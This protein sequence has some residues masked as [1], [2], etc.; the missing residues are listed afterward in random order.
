MENK[1]RAVLEVLGYNICK[2][3]AH[4]FFF[5]VYEYL[6]YNDTQSFLK[7]LDFRKSMK[8]P[9]DKS[10]EDYHIFKYMMQLLLS[11]N[12]GKLTALFPIKPEPSLRSALAPAQLLF[13][14]P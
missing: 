7:M 12:P 14:Q 13:R 11:Q 8:G 6:L 2:K 4:K 5:N 3:T 9:E 10:L 1:K